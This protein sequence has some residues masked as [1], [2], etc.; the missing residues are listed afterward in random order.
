MTLMSLLLA[1][2]LSKLPGTTFILILGYLNQEI[3]L[4]LQ[5]QRIQKGNNIT[6]IDLFQVHA[7]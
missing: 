6:G 1:Q 4:A 5:V 2:L 7:Q 3:T